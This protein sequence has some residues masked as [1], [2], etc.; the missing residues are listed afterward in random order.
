MAYFHFRSKQ[1]FYQEIGAGRP[2][3]MLHGDTA[4]S[5]MLTF[6]LPLYQENF[7]VILIDFLGNGRSDRVSS[8][9]EDLWAAQAEQVIALIEHLNLEKVNL[10]GTSGGA[11]AAINTAL[12]RPDLIGKVVADSFDGRTLHDRFAEDLRKERESAK[13][14]AQARQFYAWCQG[15]DWENVVDLNTQALTACAIGHI[16]LFCQPLETLSVPVLLMG[17]LADEMC[18]KDMAEEYTAMTRLIPN[19]TIHLFDTGGHPAVLSNAEHSASII[20]AYL[21]S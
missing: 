7:R 14:D 21:N 8:F 5:R 9:P 16:P 10:L 6:L 13:H 18:R 3:I 19:G 2:L 20:T 1:I 15:E 4:S 12:K 17:S 11:W